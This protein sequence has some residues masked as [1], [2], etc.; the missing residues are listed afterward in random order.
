VKEYEADVVIVGFGGAGACA[1]LEAADAGA[2]VIVLEKADEGGGSTRESGG[3]M[4]VC[5]DPVKAA[6]HFHAL[7]EGATPLGMTQTFANGLMEMP[8]WLRA[9]GAKLAESTAINLDAPRGKNIFP[10]P[11][12]TTSFVNY[13]DSDGVGGRLKVVNEDKQGGG[14]TLWAVLDAAVQRRPIKVHYSSPGKRL[15]RDPKKGITSVIASTPEGDIQVKARRGVILTCGGFNYNHE[16]QRQFIGIALP[17]LSPPGR[18][19]GDGIKMAMDVGA[20]LWHMNAVAGS[21]GFKVPGFEAAFY[22]KLSEPGFFI[23]DKKGN[24]YINETAVE[25]HSSMLASGQLHPLE[26]VR[27]RAPSFLIFDETTR[28]G[29]PLVPHRRQSYNQ[30][31]PWSRDSSE[32]IKKGWIK[33][34]QTVGDLAPQLDL[35]RDALE[36]SAKRFNEGCDKR[37]DQFKRPPE[38]MRR[39][40]KP[41]FYGIPIWPVLLNTQGG[42]RRNERAQI[43]D[44]FGEPI[45]RLYSAGELGSMWASLY[46][47]AGNVCEGIVFGR[48]AGRNAAAEPPIN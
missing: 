7:T 42:P 13:P 3:S 17:A 44:V 14:F 36:A 27:T 9:Q 25:A 12:P 38:L 35:P 16:M 21:Y 34:G 8:D 6:N 37:Q 1:A 19:T 26:G 15:V 30:R 33:V 46:P 39:V 23:V 29:A 41:P 11:A 22:A 31:H 24:R 43:M 32:E 48:I 40:A 47:G 18:N 10:Y 4:R 5:A 28:L 2:S 45:P 20:D